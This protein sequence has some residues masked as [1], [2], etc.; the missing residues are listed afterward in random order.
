MLHA[1]TD[2]AAGRHS[3][4]EARRLAQSPG[5]DNRPTDLPSPAEASWEE[6]NLSN[7]FAQAGN[8]F[9]LFRIM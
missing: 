5:H 4:C 6:K 3:N 2:G 1:P 9:P 8:R 7:G